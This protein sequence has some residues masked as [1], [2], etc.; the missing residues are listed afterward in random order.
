MKKAFIIIGSLAVVLVASFYIWQ[1]QRG[2]CCD[3]NNK[4]S[5]ICE[6]SCAAKDVDES[7]IKPQAT[8]KTGEFA[9]CPVSGVVFEVNEGSPLVIYEDK[10]AYTCCQTCEGLFNETPKQ[11]AANIH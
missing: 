11:F 3:F 8:A 4:M 10:S 1:Y 9:R 6:F 7:K 2:G 5:V